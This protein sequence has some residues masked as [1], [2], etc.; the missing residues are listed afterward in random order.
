MVN[1]I[2]VFVHLL[3]LPHKYFHHVH[4]HGCKKKISVNLVFVQINQWLRFTERRIP[5]QSHALK[6]MD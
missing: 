5:A 2:L 1:P 3:H 4:A 6:L